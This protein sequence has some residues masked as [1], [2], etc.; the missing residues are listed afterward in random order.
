M[1]GYQMVNLVVPGDPDEFS[2]AGA[3]GDW[4]FL[5][6][7]DY[8]TCL[9]KMREDGAC[10]ETYSATHPASMEDGAAVVDA[11]LEEFLVLCLACSY[12]SGSAVTIRRSTPGSD[13]QQM[14]VGDHFPRER[15]LS[16]AGALVAN[17]A[18][19]EDLCGKFVANHSR[20]AHPSWAQVRVMVHH[21]LDALACW[22]LEDLF[23]SGTTVLQVISAAEKNRTGQDLSFLQGVTSA[24]TH[25][26]LRALSP[27]FKN[28]RNDL[29]HDGLLSGS[30]F[31]G[32]S[33]Q[34]C[35]V[36]AADMFDWL[37]DYFH[38]VLGLGAVRNRRFDPKAF[39]SLNAFSIP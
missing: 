1:I 19:F 38:A 12:A 21:F 31:R 18:E 36:I 29:V 27:D 16:G 8:V 25:F 28:M 39:R 30:R 3:S 15:E 34:D 24:A 20:T 32:K 11:A 22:S 4:R 17:R 6:H 33:K 26:G 10:A 37:D 13:V 7:S 2:I 9:V 35:A 5:R 14:T 23:L